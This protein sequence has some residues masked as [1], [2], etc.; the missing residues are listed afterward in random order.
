LP[1]IVAAGII[2]NSTT[3]VGDFL[4]KDFLSI[5]PQRGRLYM[6]YTRFGDFST[7]PYFQGQIELAVCDIK[8][9]PAHPTCFPDNSTTPYLV[10][11]PGQVCENEGA[12]P[13]VD[14]N[15]GDVYV[16]WEYNWATNFQGPPPCNTTEHVAN[17]VAY[18]PFACLTLTPVSPCVTTPK[19]VSVNI[20]TI[21]LAFIPGF[22]R[23]PFQAGNAPP[24]DFPRIAVSDPFGTVTIVW[25]DTRFHPLGDILLQSYKLV[26]LSKVQS[27]PVRINPDTGGMHFMPALRQAQASGLIDVS[28]F[29]RDTANTDSTNVD[30]LINLSPT[31]TGPGSRTRI[32][33]VPSSWDNVSSDI[34]PNFG[35]YT[36][37]YVQAVSSSPFYNDTLYV[38]WSDGRLGV[39][40][41]FEAHG[42]S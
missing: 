7:S 22:N 20:V 16:A 30:A 37:N 6:S 34:I 41:P 4:D 14:I 27:N 26:S 5:D 31:T 3:K 24:A 19:Q 12:Y 38:A 17:R 36:D 42:V 21:D 33:N 29:Q 35:D 18:V 15:K 1:T 28:Y 32:T 25:N 39:P 23:V 40:Q 2:P 9:N 13:A 11:Q 8:T 10:V